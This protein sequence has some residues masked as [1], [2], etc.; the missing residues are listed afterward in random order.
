MRDNKKGDEVGPKVQ[1]TAEDRARHRAIRAMFRNWH[2]SPEELIATGEAANFDLHGEYREL[3]P[4]VEEIKRARE[5]AGLTLAEVSRRCGIDQPALSRLENGHNKNPTL[6]TLWRYA[7]AIG[8]RLVLTTEA[9]RDTRPAQGK[10]VAVRHER[11][12]L[13]CSFAAM[14]S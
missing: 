11:G 12:R 6:D 3:R 10:A 2:P 14:S 8:R 9:I 1:W 7:A 13:P 5:A 4:F